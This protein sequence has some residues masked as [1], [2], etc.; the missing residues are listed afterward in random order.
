LTPKKAVFYDKITITDKCTLSEGTNKKI[1]CQNL[2][3]YTYCWI[4]KDI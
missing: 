1:T 2:G 3:H 4:I